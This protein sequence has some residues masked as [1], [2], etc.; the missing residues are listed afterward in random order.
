[1]QANARF[2]SLFAVLLMLSLVITAAP[3]S[4]AAGVQPDDTAEPGIANLVSRAALAESPSGYYIVRLQDPAAASYR[5]GLPGLSATNPGV[6]GVK[7]LDVNAP[8]VRAYADHLLAEQARL[9]RSIE[10]LV[11]H[12]VDVR[13]QYLYALNGMAV[14]LT[15]Q[16]A[17]QVALLPGV[18]QVEADQAHDPTTD[19]GPSWIGAPDIWVGSATGVATMGE[20]VV[21]GILDTGIN[22]DH[23]SFAAVGGD[24]YIHINPNGSGNFL[25]WCDPGNPNYSPS[26]V[27]ND[28]LIG[29]WDY[30]DASWGETGGPEDTNGHGSHTA[31]TTAGNVVQAT[32][33][34]PTAAITD[35]ISGVAPHANIIA[36]DVC[37]PSC[38]DTD[39][40]AAINQSIADGVDVLNESIG[41][42][43]D[44]F[45]GNKQVAYLGAYDAGVFASRSAGNSGPSPAT[46]GP[47]PP[48]TISVAAMTHNRTLENSLINMTGGNTTPPADITGLGFTSGYGPAPIVYAGD[49]PSG[50]TST[51]ELCGVGSLGDFISPWPAGTF[52]GE[53]VVCDRG[54]YGRVEKGANVLFSGA[55]GYVLVDNGG[56]LVADPHA[57]PGVHISV[58]DG[59][60][61]KAWLA[62]GGSDH[63]ATISGVTVSYGAANGDIMA[64]FSSR[65]P[66]TDDVLKPDVGAPG[67]SIWAAYLDNPGGPDEGAEYSFLS[68]TSM[69]SPH[70]A[71]AGALLVSLYPGWTP[72]E[73]RSALMTTSTTENTRKEDGLTPTDPHDVG[74]GRIRVDQAANAGLVLDETT[75]NFLAADPDFGGDPSTLNL[76]SFAIANCNLTCSWTRTLESTRNVTTTWTVSYTAPAGVLLTVTPMQ[77]TV[78]PMGTQVLQVDADVSGIAPS[79]WTFGEVVLSEV[80]PYLQYFPFVANQ[81]TTASAGGTTNLAA[82]PTSGHASPDVH[83][84]M[85]IKAELPSIS[86]NPVSLSSTQ[87]ADQLV[88]LNLDIENQGGQDLVWS[89][90]EDGTMA[91]SQSGRFVLWEQVANGTTGGVSDYSTSLNAG[92]YSANDF[93]ISV[94]ADIEL[95]YADGFDNSNTLGSMP[96]ITWFIYADASGVP[97]GHPEDGGGTEIWS[98]TAAPTDPEVDITNNDISLDLVA[99]GENLQLSPGTYW[100]VV[101]PTY[102]GDITSGD[103]WNWIQAAPLLSDA[104]LI[105]PA[106]IFGAGLTSWTSWPA[107]SGGAIEDLA[108]RIEGSLAATI[109]DAPSDMP[110]ASVSP[111]AGMTIPGDT[112]KVS[113]DLDSTGLSVGSYTGFLCVQSNDPL[114][115]VVPVL[116]EM[117]VIAG[118]AGIAVAPSSLSSTQTANTIL[119][120]TLTISSTGSLDLNWS[121]FEDNTISRPA[122]GGWNED[123]DSYATGSQMHGQGGW[124]GWD[125]DPSFGALTTSTQ[126]RSAPNSVAIVG[127]SDLVHEYSGS[128]SG[129]WIYTAWQYVPN[130]FSGE[131]FFILLNT[132]ADGGTKNWSV[133]VSFNSATNQVTNTG[134]SGGTLPLVKGQWVELR[135]E[136]D[137]DNDTQ[138]F[139]YDNQLLYSGTWTGEVSGGGALNIGAVDLFA[140]S[141]SVVGYDDMSLMQG[142]AACDAPDDIP[143]LQAVPSA[144]TT[145]PGSSA[146]VDV[147]FDSTGL[148]DG[149]YNASLCISSDALNDPLVEVPVELIV[150]A[151]PKIVVDP[152][153]LSSTQAADTQVMQTL[154]I[155][156]TGD[157]TLNWDIDEDNSTRYPTG[158]ASYTVPEADV[159]LPSGGGFSLT[160]SGPA[161]DPVPGS[162][163][164]QDLSRGGPTTITHSLDPLTITPANSVSCN[165]GAPDFFHTDNSY[166]RVFD[167]N[168]FGITDP[169]SVTEV[170]I[171]IEDAV[172]A[173]G[174][175][176]VDVNL[177]TLSGPLMFAN[178]TPIGS[179]SASVADQSLGLLTIPVSGVAPA[180]S[181]LVVEVFTPDGQADGNQFFIGSNGNGQTDPSYIASAP[182]GINE[183]VDLAAIGFPNMHIVMSVTGTAGPVACDLPEDI[184]W[185]SLSPASGATAP[186]AASPVEV[187]FDSTGLT[188]GTFNAALCVNSDD[189]T[190]PTVQVPIELIIP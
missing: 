145:P 34:A 38:F 137:L 134:S 89:I 138:D 73:I 176:P 16:E 28:K 53:I 41:I 153:S 12:P 76:A 113:V 132:Y 78:G 155:S 139:Y 104:Q 97:A 170:E 62:D 35:T 103:R 58:S 174:D 102:L 186:G 29:A 90:F 79:T 121:I 187:T 61:L 49:Y 99:A 1:M 26:Y 100:L 108:F 131:S 37:G 189:P 190:E 30:A 70:T 130:G 165:V 67:V 3:A 31:S 119:T 140:N 183:P 25:G 56:G 154:T 32:L 82:A 17:A 111:D 42:G 184:P 172:G 74:A 126:A 54:T 66:G 185:A 160:A 91:A 50:S 98:Y 5:G 19:V 107:L 92:A 10:Q 8:H 147:G 162:R 80:K 135:V 181:I 46:V 75:A 36:Y 44:A 161:G 188:T 163:S 15:P 136:I 168:S 96:A 43:G 33:Y 88:G 77:F 166:L 175:Q 129:N 85:A 84:P 112:T 173:G 21:V 149:T 152:T 118:A 101:Y 167:L 128:T 150:Q 178:L 148:A 7:K 179:A 39:V 157:A 86:L 55:G 23:P 117:D 141:S 63:M 87:E 24:G 69:A 59:A 182:C 125:N 18:V 48:W 47:E 64:G 105:D 9:L 144:G 142:A 51:P 2:T 151:V 106:D 45:T 93:E 164:P 57:L 143:W 156:N 124:K 40:V 27:C 52:S 65:G 146:T 122:Q 14:Q 127:A 60:T 158:P 109:C 6:N 20:G 171:G 123:F 159:T 81:T 94:S 71:G 133:Q 115:P 83:L 95:I 22:M 116:V 120:E 13:H 72:G 68:G 11:G 110:W 114:N 177:Y 169:F 4:L 180:G